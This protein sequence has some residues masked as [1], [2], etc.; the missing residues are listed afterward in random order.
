MLPRT[1]QEKKGGPATL[2]KERDIDAEKKVIAESQ[3]KGNTLR[4]YIYVVTHKKSGV[5]EVQRELHLSSSSLAQYH[6]S[7][8]VDLGLLTENGGEYFLADQIRVDVLRDFLKFGTLIVP[9]FIFYAVFFT[10]VSGFFGVVVLERSFSE[11]DLFLVLMLIVSSALFWYE[12]L[13]A[14]LRGPI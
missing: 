13:R 4:T 5:R 8:L 7:K 10:I 3:L 2:S 6:L 1:E 14:W 12:A 9:R 11:L